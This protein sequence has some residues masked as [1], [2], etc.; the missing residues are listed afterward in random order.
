MERNDRRARRTAAVAACTLPL[1]LLGAAGAAG[2]ADA[3]AVACSGV[4]K[5]INGDGFADLAIGE[6]GAGG[7]RVH[8]LY[9]T[10]AGVATQP[11]GDAPDDQIFQQGA[12]GVPGAN[13]AGDSFG[14]TTL[15][16][17]LD[18]DG[19]AD[20]AV[21]IP[22]NNAARGAVIVLFGSTTGIRTAGAEV[23][24]QDDVEE[25]G[26]RV[27]AQ[28]GASLSAGDYNADGLRD[29]AVGSPFDSRFGVPGAGLVSVLYGTVDG[30][31]ANN[32]ISLAGQDSPGWPG[33]SERGDQF[34]LAL[35]TADFTGD[36]IDDLAISSPGENADA[37]I[38]YVS[39]G[40]AGQRLE[41]RPGRI[42]SQDTAGVPGVMESGDFFGWS[43]A[44]GDINGDGGADLVIGVPGENKG[45]G[46]VTTVLTDPATRALSASR[47]K[48]LAQGRS[49]VTG[50]PATDDFFG[51]A[52]AVGNFDSDGFADLAVGTPNDW[53]GAHKRVGSVN[54][55]KGTAT[56]PSVAGYGGTR[57]SQ[58]SAGVP[59]G[60]ETGDGF[61]ALLAT[62]RVQGGTLDSLVV[63]VP[64]ETLGTKTNS[65]A[66]VVLRPSSS[67]LTGAGAQSFDPDTPGVD[68]GRWTKGFF[69]FSIDY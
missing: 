29:L 6:A 34:G 39:A 40:A 45:N 49:G 15:L 61:G 10:A 58:D 60:A 48:D 22:G 23:F 53:L 20:L 24:T 43:L 1:V 31:G 5:D 30:L 12:G 4:P 46:L 62:R 9:G 54:L 17:D 27:D 8:V 16:D 28:F 26:A 36:G 18:N 33:A 38:V 57:L 7:G 11:T 51:N 47:V 55:F 19:C 65:G 21:G 64:S 41:S 13:V 67:G 63:A 25:G 35:T 59:G 2:P 32:F 52:V 56:G 66:V 50:A 37:G 3:V 68:G 69:G 42:W 44:A 14:A